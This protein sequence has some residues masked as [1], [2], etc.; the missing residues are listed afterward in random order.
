[1]FLEPVPIILHTLLVRY[2]HAGSDAFAYTHEHSKSLSRARIL[3][4]ACRHARWQSRARACSPSPIYCASAQFKFYIFPTEGFFLFTR[5]SAWTVSLAR[6]RPGV[7]W[8]GQL[9]RSHVLSRRHW[10]WLCE[11]WVH[12]GW[13]DTLRF[14]FGRDFMSHG[15]M[16][17][18]MMR[19]TFCLGVTLCGLG[20]CGMARY[21]AGHVWAW[22]CELWDCVVWRDVLCVL[23]G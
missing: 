1:M 3:L 19:C 5:C 22:L 7:K 16:W 13:R 20:S 17:P 9:M 11:S 4:L 10:A 8:Q 12:V 21:V 14:M 18:G 15:I 23:F 2:A 6:A